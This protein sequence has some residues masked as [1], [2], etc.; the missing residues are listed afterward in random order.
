VFTPVLAKLRRQSG[1]YPHTGFDH[2]YPQMN[3]ILTAAWEAVSMAHRK[4]SKRSKAKTILRLPDRGL[5]KNVVLHSLA[6]PVLK[7][8]TVMPS[9]N[10]SAGC[11]Y[12]K[13]H[14]NEIWLTIAMGLRPKVPGMDLP[15]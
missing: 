10:S 5:P 1:N 3:D 8:H 15:Q 13:R 14:P 11:P 4:K 9:T 12:R 6:A 2:I 7:N